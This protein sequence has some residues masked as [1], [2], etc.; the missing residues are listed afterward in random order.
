MKPHIYIIASILSISLFVSCDTGNANNIQNAGIA[1]NQA[2]IQDI[3]RSLSQATLSN[4]PS[5][6]RGIWV[7]GSGSISVEP[8]IAILKLGVETVGKTVKKSREEA[9][10]KTNELLDSLNDHSVEKKDI[11]THSFNI[12]PQYTYQDI[13]E[14][15]HR[16]SKQ[17]ITGYKVS[18]KITVNVRDLQK[19]GPIVDVASDVAG[20][21]IRIDSISFELEDNSQA[22]S[23][24]R[25]KAVKDAIGK[26]NQF[27][28]LTSIARGHIIYISESASPSYKSQDINLRGMMEAY[29]FSETP[30]TPG[31]L[32]ITIAI[33]AVF[34]IDNN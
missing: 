21:S 17:I 10:G 22:V 30:I 14:N 6:Q 34:A 2:S 7:S 27:A 26:A 13:N 9:A 8:D 32:D 1:N 16:Y 15:G 5:G 12:Y 33:Q 4:N 20:D 11:R 31:Q 18:N 25:E 3:S 19:I 29:D 24:A 28:E 23:D